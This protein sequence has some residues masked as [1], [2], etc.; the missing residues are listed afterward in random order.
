MNKFLHLTSLFLFIVLSGIAQAPQ[1]TWQKCLGGSG[2]D[3]FN[4]IQ[5]T[6]DGGYILA[7]TTSSTDGNVVNHNETQNAW[8]VKVDK[9][10]NLVWQRT[11]GGIHQDEA[12]VVRQTLDGG[13]IA[14]MTLDVGET[15]DNNANYDIVLYKLSASGETLW[16]KTISTPYADR[17]FDIQETFEGG[18]VVAA[19]TPD[20]S[21]YNNSI[22]PS[23]LWIIRLTDAG[24]TA[25]EKKFSCLAGGNYGAFGPSNGYRIRQTAEGGFI[26]AGSIARNHPLSL[27]DF[28]I[29][30][31]DAA[32]TLA[33]E[34][35]IGKPNAQEQAYDIRQT[36]D[37]GYI[38]I[39]DGTCEVNYPD[40]STC[41]LD[42]KLLKLDAEG[43]VSWEKYYT[44]SYSDM[45]YNIHL[46]ND[47]GYLIAGNSIGYGAA[48]GEISCTGSWIAKTD[49]AGN[50]LWTKCLEGALPAGGDCVLEVGNG[51]YI[52]AGGSVSDNCHAGTLDAVLMK[53]GKGPKPV[54]KITE[55]YNPDKYGCATGKFSFYFENE[56]ASP[57]KVDLH[58]K[59]E[60][61]LD[62]VLRS[63]T[64]TDIS[65]I[66]LVEELEEG[67]YFVKCRDAEGEVFESVV[68]ILT[69]PEMQEVYLDHIAT[70]T[71]SEYDCA[72]G[73]LGFRFITENCFESATARLFQRRPDGSTIPKGTLDIT[74]DNPD[75]VF[76]DLTAG[77]Y[78]ALV[79]FG[80]KEARS[81]DIELK[82]PPPPCDQLSINISVDDSKYDELCKDFVTVRLKDASGSCPTQW[83][84]YGGLSGDGV[85][86]PPGWT[87][88]TDPANPDQPIVLETFR[89]PEEA[90]ASWYASAIRVFY[91]DHVCYLKAQ[92]IN[93]PQLSECKLENTFSTRI[94]QQPTNSCTKNGIVV[95]KL[96]AE[97]LCAINDVPEVTYI[98]MGLNGYVENQIVFTNEA[99]TFTGLEAGKYE[100]LMGF[101]QGSRYCYDKQIFDM[102]ALED[103]LLVFPNPVP[104]N[105]QAVTFNLTGCFKQPVEMHLRN[106]FGQTIARQTYPAGSSTISGS[107]PFGVNGP[108][109]YSVTA[110]EGSK[111]LHTRTLMKL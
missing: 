94:L 81:E 24:Q 89:L 6:T 5:P 90:T 83:S 109:I 8:V 27:E 69:N 40:E 96:Q 66:T 14:G 39:G 68:V 65:E 33:W 12:V 85:E 37:G 105:R 47:G 55:P 61:G 18:F 63:I 71:I 84:V 42:C 3:M 35:Y 21:N 13:Y 111:L 20:V 43:N 44:G 29:L 74:Q 10:G 73:A 101:Y 31:L 60:Y 2:L 72:Q 58:V 88:P 86:F 64:V 41:S 106:M 75:V 100:I 45:G 17:I 28:W 92:K 32:G 25:W 22:Y 34:K 11:L 91:R 99:A 4:C 70:V 16:Q 23:Y 52:A 30:K 50:L 56:P 98:L 78:F 102:K 1:L 57:V 87:F 82:N 93:T 76:Q 107:L 53:F 62:K 108:G 67:E 46:T 79:K 26:I 48:S 104:A 97:G 7:G 59:D 77:V 80:D 19:W 38:V 95:F 9:S 36:P 15:N 110:Y 49:A 54:V 51:E 103:D